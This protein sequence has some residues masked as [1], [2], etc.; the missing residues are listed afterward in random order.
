[1]RSFDAR[2]PIATLIPPFYVAM[3]TGVWLALL[4][5]LGLRVITA[6]MEH[7]SGAIVAIGV[8]LL[9]G[10]IGA[11]LSERWLRPRR[12]EARGRIYAHLGVRRFRRIALR[13]DYMNAM[14]RALGGDAVT[15]RFRR[16][17]PRDLLRW[18]LRNERIHWTWVLAVPPLLLWGAVH[19]PLAAAL[20]LGAAIPLNV[21]PILLQRY[22]RARV[23]AVSPARAARPRA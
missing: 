7:R 3:V 22:T 4:A 13:G 10:A 14:L 8:A 19:A 20:A 1:M 17:A 2:R 18:N 11:T 9:G 15:P 21:Y 5:P 6:A 16:R 12:F 23:A